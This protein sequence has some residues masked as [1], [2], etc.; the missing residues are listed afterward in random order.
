MALTGSYW[1][2]PSFSPSLARRPVPLQRTA[3]ELCPWSDCVATGGILA[4]WRCRPLRA[5]GPRLRRCGLSGVAGAHLSELPELSSSEQ[6]LR[7]GRRVQR[8]TRE[9]PKGQ[10][11]VAFDVRAPASVVLERLAD[12]ANY[13]S[14][15]PVVRKAVVHLSHVAD[16]GTLTA[17]C[18]YRISRF[19][20]GVSIVHSVSRDE[21][22]VRFDLDPTVS[23]MML[24]EVTGFWYV[25][26]LDA[27]GACRVW[28]K[29]DLHAANWLPH[30]LIDYASKRAL[31]RAT[32][33][34]KPNVEQLW[35][36]MQSSEEDPE[37]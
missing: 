15:I 23:A 21:G 34:L 36:E 25:E 9:G 20:L 16:D 4:A 33:W 24:Q 19:Y 18:S 1:P 10:G 7:S 37:T 13:P 27:Q 32:S 12:F 35:S 30:W 6:R 26:A 2:C 28:L 14:M 8:Q 5:R 11:L 31:T 22:L 29:V 17:H 3:R